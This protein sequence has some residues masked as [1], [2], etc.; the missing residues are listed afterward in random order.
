MNNTELKA[1]FD[2]QAAHYD[3]QWNKTAPI[4]DGL[5]FLL[6]AV[7][8]NLP[9]DAH[10]LSIGTGTGE[11]LAYLA[12]RF[13]SWRFTAVE[14]SGEMLNV[15]R[16]KA[17]R[18]GFIT[19][20]EFHEGY[21]DSLVTDTKFAGAICLL[22]SQFILD[23]TARSAFFQQIADKL[24]PDGI[25]ASSDLSAE[26]GTDHFEALLRLW[27]RVV[28][29]ANISS[30][31]LARMRAAYSKDVAVIAPA[32]V[33]DIIAAAGFE[34]PVVF[35]QAGLIHAWMTRIATNAAR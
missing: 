7:F 23:P 6:E 30:E 3:E 20:C 27:Q 31:G 21:L 19:R 17:T 4:R 9:A 12:R 22:V 26:I 24:Q 34:P 25:L 33:A 1:I 18:E 13:P 8:A 11:E 10:I 2:Q 15:C 29:P 28:A 32:A 14:P 35:Y 16:A 5:L